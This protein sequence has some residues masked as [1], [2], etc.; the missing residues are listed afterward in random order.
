MIAMSNPYIRNAYDF[1][2]LG[3]DAAYDQ[4]VRLP[5]TAQPHE[6]TNVLDIARKHDQ[7]YTYPEI[8]EGT[9]GEGETVAPIVGSIAGGLLGKGLARLRGSGAVGSKARLLAGMGIGAALGRGAQQQLYKE[10]AQE[11][12]LDISKGLANIDR[13]DPSYTGARESQPQVMSPVQSS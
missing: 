8:V 10:P 2:K 12:A 3:R 1:R 6:V 5:G 11:G 13:P 9:G 7:G 4:Y